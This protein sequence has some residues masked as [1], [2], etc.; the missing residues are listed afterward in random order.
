[1]KKKIVLLVLA[2][3]V[4]TSGCGGSQKIGNSKAEPVIETT[5][6]N[7]DKATNE[8]ETDSTADI[9]SDNDNVDLSKLDGVEVKSEN[10]S[11]EITLPASLLEGVDKD[12]IESNTDD[13]IEKTLNDDGSVTMKMT[14]AKHI[15]LMNEYHTSLEQTFSKLLQ[16]KENYPSFTDIKTNDDFT[17]VTVY[18]TVIS[19]DELSL[20]ESFSALSISVGCGIY[21]LFNGE[22]EGHVVINYKNQDTE[23]I[24]YT[25]DSSQMK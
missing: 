6:E 22:K 14:K 24:I 19:K 8:T 3:C 18:T 16:D 7:S 12:E 10:S 9:V 23:E 11:V 17:E 13:G 20:S 2:L 15:E 25:Y 21:Q 1:M 4:S 5:P